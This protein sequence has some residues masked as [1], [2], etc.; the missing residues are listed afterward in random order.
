MTNKHREE[1]IRCDMCT[2]GMKVT[3]QKGTALVKKRTK[4]MSN[5]QEIIKIM[6]SLCTSKMESQKHKHADIT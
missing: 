4:L 3:D 2:F 1:T 5:S 6:D